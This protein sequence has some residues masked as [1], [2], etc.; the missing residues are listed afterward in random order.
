MKAKTD[1]P[2]LLFGLLAGLLLGAGYAGGA[3]VFTLAAVAG[4]WLPRVA[5]ELGFPFHQPLPQ[6]KPRLTQSCAIRRLSV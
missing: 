5:G 3:V 1:C 4:V 6:E 2:L